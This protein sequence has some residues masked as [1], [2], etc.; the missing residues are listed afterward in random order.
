[1]KTLSILSLLSVFL[2]ACEAPTPPPTRKKTASAIQDP[3]NKPNPYAIVDL[4]PLDVTYFPVNFPAQLNTTERNKPLA[5][6]L[7]G[8]PHLQGRH[9]F[10]DVVPAGQPWRLGANEATELE[11][12]EPVII[13]NKRIP[14]GR[15]SLYAIPQTGEWTI[16]I[17]RKLYTWGLDIDPA[18]DVARFTLP[19]QTPDTQLE[20]FTIAFMGTGNEAELLIGWD[21]SLVKLPI[22]FDP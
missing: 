8:R 3:A 1:M 14:E 2:F 13:Q 17:N 20:Y 5:R 21:N 7:Y 9:I 16:V 19:V 11:L 18:L 12:F 10:K 6:V 22:R 4:S 15:Y